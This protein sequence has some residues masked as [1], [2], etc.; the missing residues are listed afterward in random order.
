[1]HEVRF[2]VIVF[3][4]IKV[5]IVSFIM[6]NA[7]LHVYYHTS[8]YTE[9]LYCVAIGSLHAHKECN[10]ITACGIT[11]KKYIQILIMLGSR[12]GTN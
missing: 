12:A 4:C 9:Q 11:F 3:C 6:Q 5:T 2:I 8:I 10:M 1:M 7:V